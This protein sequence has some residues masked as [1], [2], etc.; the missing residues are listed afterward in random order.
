MKWLHNLKTVYKLWSLIIIAFLSLAAIGLTGYI[1]LKTANDNLKSMYSERLIPV[2][3]AYDTRSDIRALNGFLLEFMLTTDQG[4]NQAL[5]VSI[6]QKSDSINDKLVELE[7]MS[8]DTQSSQLFQK[9]KTSHEQYENT[10]DQ[11]IALARQNKNTEAYNLYITEGD[12]HANQLV[13]DMRNLGEYYSSLSEQ[14]ILD[15]ET[16][17][18]RS[19]WFMYSV[20]AG[21]LVLLS[22]SAFAI[23]S[24]ITKPLTVMLSVCEDFAAGDFRDKDRDAGASRQDEIGRL[25]QA[26]AALQ[27][28]LRPLIKGIA[29]SADQ[30][31]AS[32]QELTASSEQSAQAAGQIASSISQIASG[33]DQ[34]LSAADQ[35][36]SIVGQMSLSMQQVS[37]KTNQVA[38]QSNHANETANAGRNTVAKAVAQMTHIESTVNSSAEVVTK[39]GQRS[40]EIGQIVNTIAGIAEQT[41]LLALNA[42]IEAARA[43][44]QGRGFAVVAEEVRKLAEQS[45]EAAKQIAV[46]IGEVQT[47][48][49]QAVVSMNQGTRE[50]KTGAEAVNAAGQ[51][52]QEIAELV[53]Q[54][55]G[56]MKEISAALQEMDAHGQQIVGSVQRIDQ[57]S[58]TTASETQMVSAATEEQLA[59][60]EEIASSSQSLSVLAQ[61]LQTEIAKFKI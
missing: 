2:K 14:T 7:K 5:I 34:Q 20:I 36:S 24:S 11:I 42:A 3:F 13:E 48:T 56:Q 39:L 50:V 52:F 38:T 59:S 51:A 8:V 6:D 47:D 18:S 10:Q 49:E 17:F 41:N 4:K 25:Y 53:T 55:S 22:I 16:K 19:L 29:E 58:N 33:A 46:M 61:N 9:I 37:T 28:N 26:L 23:A 15:D 21:T 1:S 12:P 27:T 43:G 32:S 57:I 35:S 40:Q 60:M 45:Q 31:A 44:E 30:L 54:V